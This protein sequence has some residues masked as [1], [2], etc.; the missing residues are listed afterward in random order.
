MCV[1]TYVCACVCVH[2]CVRVCVCACV[3]VCVRVTIF[4]SIVRILFPFLTGDD[5]EVTAVGFTRIG[6]SDPDDYLSIE[7]GYSLVHPLVFMRL[8][9]S[10]ITLYVLHH[11]TSDK[12]YNLGLE[13]LQQMDTERLVHYIH[14]PP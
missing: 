14:F 12:M 13:I 1:C 7:S 11:Q 5:R 4:S 6:S 2:V 3:C 8:F 10:L 9:P